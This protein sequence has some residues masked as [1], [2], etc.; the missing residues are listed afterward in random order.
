MIKGAIFDLDD[1]L[2][3]YKDINEIA[4]NKVCEY[5]CKQLNI[6][7]NTFYTAFELGRENTKKFMT[8]DCAAKHNRIIYFQKTLESLGVNPIAYALEMYDIYWNTMLETMELNCGVIELFEYL[9][10][11]KIKIAVCT[12]LTTHIQH[13]KLRKL[14]IDKYIDCIVTSEEAGFEK[15]N[16]IM[17]KLCLDKLGLQPQETFYV[18]DSFKKDIIGAY[19]MGSAPI[20]FAEKENY[21]INKDIEFEHI[22]SITEVI[23]IVEKQLRG[24]YEEPI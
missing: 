5:I 3:N 6:D 10:R 18:G 15:P 23:N 22:K 8:Y 24:I 17:F 7:K 4:I 9:K 11:N 21:I 12:D 2:Y 13:R 20:W 14:G 1:T 19:N 16:P